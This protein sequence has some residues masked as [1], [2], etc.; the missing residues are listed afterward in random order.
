MLLARKSIPSLVL[1]A[2]R[3]YAKAFRSPDQA[4]ED[5]LKEQMKSDKWW[6]RWGAKAQTKEFNSG[7]TKALIVM[8]IGFLVYGGLYF[9]D[10]YS[11]EK[12]ANH[13]AVKKYGDEDHK[14]EPLNEYEETRLKELT[15]KLRTR[16]RKRL[17]KYKA[18][19]AEKE[20]AFYS[21]PKNVGKIYEVNPS[22]FDG[23]HVDSYQENEQNKCILPSCDTLSF[24]DSKAEEYDSD[25]NWEE[26]LILMGRRRKWLVRKAFGDVLEVA[27][28][29][30]RNIKY[31]D[32]TKINSITFL[33]PSKKMVEL[34][35][36]KFREKHPKYPRA[37][38]VVGKAEELIELAGGKTAPEAEKV[39]ESEIASVDVNSKVKYDTIIESF[40]LCSHED[41]VK[42]L[43]NFAKLLKPG[44]RIILLEHGRGTWDF[45]N[46][47]LDNR[48]EKR[49]NTWGCRWNLDI[50][51]IIDDLG[52]E[53]VEERR[54]QL[55][56]LWCIVAKRP[57]DV[58]RY[59][60]LTLY[61]KYFKSI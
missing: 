43:K 3:P 9:K 13:L 4:K 46:N 61:E 22:D 40:G 59:D 18:M 55:G 29:T 10:M 26:R 36:K 23:V 7:V 54:H 32:V 51:E 33:D 28:G 17:E 11:K 38:F 48:A 1:C 60:E 14:P 41:P 6:V 47:H 20:D 42:A 44:G 2:R 45:I 34:T 25:I 58:K 37:A 50:G 8:Y 57:G 35:Q 12:E 21:D 15:G 53:I 30:G 27:C 52:L 31:L 19:I 24:Y 56:T 49:L 16:D 5:F 39:A